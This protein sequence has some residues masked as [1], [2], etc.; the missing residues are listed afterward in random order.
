MNKRNS[1]FEIFQKNLKVI[2]DSLEASN[3]SKALKHLLIAETIEPQNFAV[4]N[5]IG[6]C[7]AKL[8]NHQ[9]AFEYHCR[10]AS[11]SSE[12][13]IIIANIGLDLSKL[14]RFEESIPYFQKSIELDPQSS[15]P[16]IGLIN[17]FHHLG[18]HLK[19]SQLSIDAISKFPQMPEFHS[20]L[21]TALIGL[22]QLNEAEY[23]IDT[24]L[25]LNP[26]QI[27]TKLN[28]GRLKSLRHKHEE[29]IGIFEEA[30]QQD[31]T[32]NKEYIP[33]IKYNL[34][35]EYFWTGDLARGWDYYDF[36]FD[37]HVNH[38]QSRQ[39]NRLFDVSRWEGEPLESETLLVWGEQGLGDEI[40]FLSMLNDVS[41]VV[42]NIVVECDHRLVN[43]VKRSFPKVKVRASNF[44]TQF[45]TENSDFDFQIPMGS[46]GKIFR[47]TLNDFRKNP[48]YLVPQKINQAELNNFFSEKNE[49]IKIGFCWR[50]GTLSNE[51]DINYIP[52]Q[53]WQ[54]IFNIPNAVFINLQYGE[55]ELELLD[56]E[57]LFNVT[58]HRWPSIDLKS[59]LETVFSIIHEL[60]VVVTA[61]T[62]VSSMAYSIGK[63][64]LTFIPFFDWASFGTNYFPWSPNMIPFLP[65]EGEEIKS[66]L[67]SISNYIK[68]N[69]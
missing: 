7:Y 56:A 47:R 52:L 15:I 13:S 35:Y 42:K 66:T 27:D 19:V 61:G 37:T 57:K 10:A 69:F 4:I 40:M 20:S 48:S 46:L 32:V 65:I 38:Y 17:V 49:K 36:G 33:V 51:R 26:K 2:Q 50:S 21:G 28:L 24:A 11:I 53:D 41:L 25:L 6:T 12:N 5:E 67:S 59:D 34:S 18:D 44:D 9:K 68:E 39:P 23:C 45:K 8:G 60:D 62:A 22:N 31:Q 54:E 3:F 64:S 29:A 58:I 63:P 30:L 14:H 55:C 1:K 16:Y 43:I